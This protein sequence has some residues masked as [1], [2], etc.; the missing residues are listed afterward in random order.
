MQCGGNDLENLKSDNDIK[1]VYEDI[2]DLVKLTREVF[3]NAKIHLL[4]SIPRRS[5]YNN[6]IRNMHRLNYWLNSF[7]TKRSI[8]FVN[9]FSFL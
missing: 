3:P 5:Q 7:C 4:S 9:I 1:F 8:R 6:H 2:E